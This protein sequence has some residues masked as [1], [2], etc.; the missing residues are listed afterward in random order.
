MAFL[1]RR[2][3]PNVVGAYG[4]LQP[5]AD[6]IKLVVKESVT[7][8]QS[9]GFL[10]IAAPVITLVTAIIG[11]AVI[12][13]NGV[14]LLNSEIS[15]LYSLAV[16]GL[17]VYGVL[18]A[19]WSANS[20]YALLGSLRSTAQMISYELV[21]GAG[22]LGVAVVAG[23]LNL[24]RIL[25]LQEG[26]WLVLPLLPLAIM[27]AISILAETNRTPFDLPEAES[28]LV[29]GFLTEHSAA[30]FVFF[31]LGEYCSVLLISA[32]TSALFLGGSLL[33]TIFIVF[34]FIWVRATL[35]RVRFDQLMTGAWT[36]LI[37]IALGLLS[38]VVSAVPLLQG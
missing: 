6:A 7:P 23:S 25:E 18:L 15:L 36:V 12:P 11:W 22:A 26:V 27:F 13:V 38:I 34:G 10:F 14:V 20:K 35:P 33:G 37:P 5:F 1:Q 16:S 17:S 19:G 29:A 30:P 28:E 8:Q 21:L 4:T 9:N 2:I 24:I 3:G 32:L 31:F